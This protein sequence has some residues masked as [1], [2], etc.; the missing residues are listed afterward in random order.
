[1]RNIEVIEA[2]EI[3]L[4]K[5]ADFYGTQAVGL[6]AAFIDEFERVVRLIVDFPAIGAP[7]EAGTRRVLLDRFPYAAVY[8]DRPDGSLDLIAVM[9]L[10]REPGYW[11]DR[12]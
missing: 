7:Y 3:E 9:H 2:A 4:S 5:A 12:L 11:R 1:V 10:H 6:R 8:R